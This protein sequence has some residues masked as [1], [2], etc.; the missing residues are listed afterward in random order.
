MGD[1]DQGTGRAPRVAPA[2]PSIAPGRPEGATIH[3]FFF[4]LFA[5]EFPIEYTDFQ[6]LSIA[7][8]V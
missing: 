3:R 8:F 4:P 6:G 2:P 1:D 5:Y 7:A